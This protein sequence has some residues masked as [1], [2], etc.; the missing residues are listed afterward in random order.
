M[1]GSKPGDTSAAIADHIKDY[2][3]G[4][5]QNLGPGASL[6]CFLRK[7]GEKTLKELIPALRNYTDLEVR[8]ALRLDSLKGRAKK[9]AKSS[10][11]QADNNNNTNGTEA[12]ADVTMGSP[13]APPPP[14]SPPPVKTPTG[15]A[16]SSTAS[17][18][19]QRPSSRRRGNNVGEDFYTQYH[20]DENQD[21]PHNHNLSPTRSVTTATSPYQPR[22][23]IH[24]K[25]PPDLDSVTASLSNF[26]LSLYTEHSADQ[27]INGALPS[28]LGAEMIA[29]I[30]DPTKFTARAKSSATAVGSAV[31][32]G[33]ERN[34]IE[35]SELTGL[36]KE[37]VMEESNRKLNLNAIDDAI[38]V[39]RKDL[40]DA[41]AVVKQH[42]VQLSNLEEKKA[43]AMQDK[44]EQIGKVK[45]FHTLA[46]HAYA[47]LKECGQFGCQKLDD[48]RSGANR[49][50]NKHFRLQEAYMNG[51]YDVINKPKSDGAEKNII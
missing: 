6:R 9:E 17:F 49:L 15:T 50:I 2:Y 24:P 34:S 35:A 32:D 30:T 22:R 46:I 16:S 5:K 19:Q 23:I 1:T 41:E 42:Q 37:I 36:K 26:S 8:N 47:T 7:K 39:K 12:E 48:V 3:D 27:L 18:Y 44:E 38:A 20:D 13:P 40:A 31:G 43:K 45:A 4:I 14:E 29:I 10:N 21:L 28:K 33:F 51:N 11:M 25:L